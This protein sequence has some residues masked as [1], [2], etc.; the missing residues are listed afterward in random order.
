MSSGNYIITDS[1]EDTVKLR[2]KSDLIMGEL[3]SLLILLIPPILYGVVRLLQNLGGQF[4]ILSDYEETTV[5]VLA[6]FEFLIVAL[7]VYKLYTRLR[8]HSKRDAKWR[9][10]LL[11]NLK[12]RGA[13]I[14]RMEAV[15]KDICTKEKFRM[16]IPA[17]LVFLT[18]FASIAFFFAFYIPDMVSNAYHPANEFNVWMSDNVL[19]RMFQV[20]GGEDAQ[21]DMLFSI[22]QLESVLLALLFV[23]VLGT[24]IRFIERHELNQILF[25]ERLTETMN[26]AGYSIR[27]MERKVGNKRFDF[28]TRY[29]DSLPSKIVKA[30]STLFSLIG[31]KAF[32]VF[33]GANN[34]FRDQWV[35]ESEL[36]GALKTG[37]G[38]HFAYPPKKSDGKGAKENKMPRMLIVALAFI[39][40]MCADYC[41]KVMALEYDMV[42]DFSPY[43]NL[44]SLTANSAREILMTP[45]T[46][47]I[48]LFLLITTTNALLGIASRRPASW[49]KVTRSC[50]TFIIPIWI[51]ELVLNPTGL[52]HLFDFNPYV[53]TGILYN[54]L[55][56][57]VL[58]IAIR[59]FYTPVGIDMPPIRAWIRYIAY[60]KLEPKEN[61]D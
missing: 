28:T 58:S 51:G 1:F 42:S 10:S 33:S 23:M 2:Y 6:T 36:L 30:L 60:G 8:S 59:G 61:N 57:M 47:I 55:L 34:H 14:E 16:M 12:G 32:I 27:P 22:I 44:T 53:T 4:D 52:V 50:I 17:T 46:I 19:G 45:G 21:K 7:V 29:N 39:L 26:R 49:Q 5:L 38:Y 35:Y 31:H 20:T 54:V 43:T 9:E 11:T 15:H 56:I 41:L 37:Q 13:N 48:D 18:I 25:T 40:V 3:I 24:V